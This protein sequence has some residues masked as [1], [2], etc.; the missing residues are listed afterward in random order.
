M[1]HM[2]AAAVLLVAL[3]ATVQADEV[4][5]FTY[6][7]A[8]LAN[9]ASAVKIGTATAILESSWLHRILKKETTITLIDP[10]NKASVL[11]NEQIADIMDEIHSSL[12]G[13]LMLTHDGVTKA[14]T[15]QEIGEE[16]IRAELQLLQKSGA[17][18]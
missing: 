17:L 16:G 1:K 5:K 6:K 11:S 10:I 9:V 14:W 12:G 3:S 4:K 15:T 7:D 18:V 13:K 8:A 2:I